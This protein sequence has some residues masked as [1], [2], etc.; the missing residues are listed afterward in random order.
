MDVGFPHISPAVSD[1]GM[2]VNRGISLYISVSDGEE[3]GRRES[4]RIS[5]SVSDRER[6]FMV[7]FNP[8]HFI[9]IRWGKRRLIGGFL[10]HL[11]IWIKF[12]EKRLK[13]DFP[14]H[15][16][17]SIL[18]VKDGLWG[19]TPHMS[20]SVSDG[21]KEGGWGDSP[22]YFQNKMGNWR[23]IGGFPPHLFIRIR[24]GEELEIPPNLSVSIIWRKRMHYRCLAS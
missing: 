14:P 20:L 7:G 15:I 12:K 22:R 24:W 4:P 3:G 13:G 17:F 1:G 9:S 16:F 8:H 23:L 2:K 19:D 5:L 10:P 18:W 11:S 6:S 21:G